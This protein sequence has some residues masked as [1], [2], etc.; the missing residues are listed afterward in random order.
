M[1]EN[2]FFEFYYTKTPIKNGKHSCDTI[3]NDDKKT[4]LYDRY[5]K[6]GCTEND[7]KKAAEY[8]F[9]MLA[10]SKCSKNSIDKKGLGR[11]IHVTMVFIMKLFMK[12]NDLQVWTFRCWQ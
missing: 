3:S 1:D 5:L 2:P 10:T 11:Q 8:I 12:K 4:W 7:I 6:F 9:N